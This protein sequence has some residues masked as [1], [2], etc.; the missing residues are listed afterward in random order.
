M[1][2]EDDIS[3]EVLPTKPPSTTNM[4]T[5]INIPT[6]LI[7]SI[8]FSDY[9][10]PEVISGC[11]QKHYFCKACFT[12]YL[13]HII[14]ES[15]VLE[16]V[17]PQDGCVETIDAQF[18]ESL[19]S[20]SLFEKYKIRLQSLQGKTQI[21]CPKHNCLISNW[22]DAKKEFTVCECGTHM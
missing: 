2:H 4:D 17:C 12:Q 22:I 10:T 14:S 16:I 3:L 1:N 5:I 8:C 6:I 11:S 9:Q 13:E 19:I 7:C 18:I 20:A 15:K 21:T